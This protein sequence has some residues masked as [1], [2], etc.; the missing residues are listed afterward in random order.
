MWIGWR[1]GEYLICFTYVSVQLLCSYF[2][3]KAGVSFRPWDLLMCICS[4][5]QG[6]ICDPAWQPQQRACMDFPYFPFL[7]SGFSSNSVNHTLMLSWCWA[8]G[9]CLGKI[10]HCDGRGQLQD[11]LGWTACD[12]QLVVWA[13]LSSPA[14]ITIKPGWGVWN[15]SGGWISV[16]CWR[17]MVGGWKM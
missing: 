10:C 9:V 13:H 7:P 2:R 17:I 3:W 6:Y 15:P 1:I 12:L 8:M 11:G 14:V 4:A 16:M 5:R